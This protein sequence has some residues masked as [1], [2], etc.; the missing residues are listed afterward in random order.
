M[1]KIEY[2]LKGKN[3]E[4]IYKNIWDAV[5]NGRIILIQI[6]NYAKKGTFVLEIEGSPCSCNRSLNFEYYY[7]NYSHDTVAVL[8]EDIGDP[9]IKFLEEIKDED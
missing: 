4:E 1:K 2:E 7:H 6:K 8:E 3:K 5:Y 9:N